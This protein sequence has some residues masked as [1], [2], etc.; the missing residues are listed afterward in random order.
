MGRSR[1]EEIASI[2]CLRKPEKRSSETV[3]LHG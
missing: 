3:F 1:F 2:L